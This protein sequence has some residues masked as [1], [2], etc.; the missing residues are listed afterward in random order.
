MNDLIS[1]F[2]NKKIISSRIGVFDIVKTILYYDHPIVFICSKDVNEVVEY[3][4]FIEIEDE[5]D[6]FGWNISKI[7][8]LDINLANRGV[9]TIQSLFNKKDTLKYQLLFDLTKNEEIC[10]KVDIFEGKYAIDGETYIADFC[11]MDETFDYHGF[12]KASRTTKEDRI[13]IV[14]EDEKP[15]LVEN[16]LSCIK[17]MNSLDVGLN[18]NK[19]RLQTEHFSTVLSFIFEEDRGPL[20]QNELPSIHAE[21]IRKIKRLFDSEDELELLDAGDGKSKIKKLKKY[22]KLISTLSSVSELRPKIVVTTQSDSEQKS[23]AMDKKHVA[24]KKQAI[25]K[26]ITI[27]E[28]KS[29]IDEHEFDVVGIFDAISVT[30][31]MFTFVEKDSGNKINGKI[32][33]SNIKSDIIIAVKDVEYTATIKKKMVSNGSVIQKETYT[34]IDLKPGKMIKRF[35]KIVLP[36]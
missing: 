29:L 10:R 19:A 5:Q 4:A 16:V 35:E 24:N 15:P 9:K 28:E 11:D 22:N 8:L 7:E 26:A 12:L 31:K 17:T 32:D 18:F 34:L 2:I 3:Y 20:L 25:K 21:G 14:F 36:L 1:V 27:I 6:L 13:S 33:F 23:F 30:K